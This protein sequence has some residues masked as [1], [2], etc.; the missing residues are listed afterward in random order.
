MEEDTSLSLS[1]HES[2]DINKFSSQ[3]ANM[4]FRKGDFFFFLRLTRKHIINYFL[5]NII[6]YSSKNNLPCTEIIIIVALSEI[7][8]IVA[9]CEIIIIAF[10]LSSSQRKF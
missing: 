2:K 7:I 1:G 6:D 5:Y 3:I 8:I 10:S 9:L 4:A